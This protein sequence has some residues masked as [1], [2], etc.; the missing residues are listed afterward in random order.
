[1][2]LLVQQHQSLKMVWRSGILH[3]KDGLIVRQSLRMCGHLGAQRLAGIKTDNTKLALSVLQR[4]HR[5]DIEPD[6][7]LILVHISAMSASLRAD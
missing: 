6:G 7:P 2:C 4:P 3:Y 5:F 1:M